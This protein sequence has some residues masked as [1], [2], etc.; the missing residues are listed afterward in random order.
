MVY[1][2]FSRWTCA[3][4]KFLL[5]TKKALRGCEKKSP[6]F[7]AGEIFISKRL[8]GFVKVGVNI[9]ELFQADHIQN[10][11]YSRLRIE[12]LYMFAYFSVAC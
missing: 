4:K 7:Q 1:F 8:D 11:V 10:F 12:Q 6:V 2:I 5:V 3:Q 9:E